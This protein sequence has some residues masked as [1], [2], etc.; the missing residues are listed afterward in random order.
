MIHAGTGVRSVTEKMPELDMVAIGPDILDIH[1]PKEK[2]SIPSAIRV[3]DYLLE[4]L[5]ELRKA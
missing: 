1:T 3:Y 5:Q 2:L 4:V